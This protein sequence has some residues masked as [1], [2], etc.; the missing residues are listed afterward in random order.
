MSTFSTTN[1]HTNQLV[2]VENVLTGQGG[3][4]KSSIRLVILLKQGEGARNYFPPGEGVN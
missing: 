2:N 3:C 1:I 4:L